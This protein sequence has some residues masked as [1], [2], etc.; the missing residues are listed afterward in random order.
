LGLCHKSWP[1]ADHPTKLIGRIELGPTD[2]AK[3][4]CYHCQ[5]CHEIGCL[6]CRDHGARTQTKEDQE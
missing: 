2:T 5:W 4:E 6:L 3:C 1:C